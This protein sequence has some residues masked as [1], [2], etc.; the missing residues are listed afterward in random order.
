MNA[1]ATFE[2][3]AKI[4]LTLEVLGTRQDGYHELR[5]VVQPVT[6]S[7]TLEISARGDGRIAVETISAGAVDIDALPAEPE[8]NL[9]WRAADALSRAAGMPGTGVTIRILKRIPLGGGLGGGS[10]DAAAA[11]VA[12]NGLWGLGFGRE[13]LAEIGAD[14][15]SDVPALTLGGPVLMEGRGE[16]VTRWTAG[17]ASRPEW[18]FV[19]ANP[20]IHSST[21]AVFRA[22]DRYLHLTSGCGM[23]DNMRR[24]FSCGSVDALA[25]AMGND[26]TEAAC[27][28]Y[29]QIAETVDA[30]KRAG[31]LNA[32]LTGSGATVAGAVRDAKHGEA[33]RSRLGNSFWTALVRNCPVV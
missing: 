20:G 33:V 1:A 23:T 29:P 26:L 4:N 30:L 25:A 13:R 16:R 3:F 12:L 22:A 5:S 27:T 10:A 9:A 28:L 8:K 7:D 24:V 2:A 11:L 14:V 21:P 32:V 6:L 18:H 15:G 17:A 19:L 31:A